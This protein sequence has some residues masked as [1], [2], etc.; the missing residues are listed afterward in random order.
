MVT[1]VYGDDD[2]LDDD[3]DLDGRWVVDV[4][5]YSI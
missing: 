3:V 2:D 5:T 1:L 4:Y